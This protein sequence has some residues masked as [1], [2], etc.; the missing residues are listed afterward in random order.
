M[1]AWVE[2]WVKACTEFR[3]WEREN[4]LVKYPSQATVAEHGDLIRTLIWSARVLQAMIADPNHPARELRS[5]VDGLLHQLEESCEMIH[6]PLSDDQCDALLR[7]H[8]PHEPGTGSA[9]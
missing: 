2:A 4:L 9:P 3:R 8:F 5:E 7:E 6:N 1:R